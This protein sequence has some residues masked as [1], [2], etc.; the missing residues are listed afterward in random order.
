METVDLED[1]FVLTSNFGEDK[2]NVTLVETVLKNTLNLTINIINNNNNSSSCV[3]DPVMYSSSRSSLI[4]WVQ[5]F[6]IFC[7]SLLTLAL[8]TMITCRRPRKT[9]QVRLR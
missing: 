9:V 1:N 2:E 6:G 4:D 3:N 7:G 5:M 8:I